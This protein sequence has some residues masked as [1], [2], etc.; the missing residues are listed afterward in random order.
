[1]PT[2]GSI[3]QLLNQWESDS[4]NALNGVVN[5]AYEK[6]WQQAQVLMRNERNNHTLETSALVNETYIRLL[7]I[8]KLD[9]KDR[10][11]FYAVAAS[12]MRRILVDHARSKQSQK[13]GGNVIHLTVDQC[14]S[15]ESNMVDILALSNAM[16]GLERRDTIQAQIVELRYF[17]GFTITQLAEYLK[18]SPATIKRKWV[19]AQAWLYREL[20]EAQ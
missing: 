15:N 18:L 11:H 12:I 16:T 13:R 14:R 1:M 10:N 3:T 2:P 5:E 20:S 9:W 8:S 19:F 7:D 4:H 17:G 6:L